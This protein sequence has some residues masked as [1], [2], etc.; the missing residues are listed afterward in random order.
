MTRDWKWVLAA[1]LLATALAI[2]TL[3]DRT[4][5]STLALR[6]AMVWDYQLQK[7]NLD[8]LQR[9]ASDLV[10]MDYSRDGTGAKALTR[11]DVERVRE[12]SDG[13]RRLVIAYLSIGE[14]EEYRYY[15]QPSWKTDPPQWLF[16]ENCRWPGN[17]LVKFW[18]SDWKRLVYDDADSYLAKI[19]AAGFDG[20]YLDR[21]DAYWDM[22]ETYPDGRARMLE[23]VAELSRKA[24]TLRKDFLVIAQNAEDLLSDTAYLTA[25]DAIAKEDLLFGVQ[26]SGQ[27]NDPKLVA[28]SISQLKRLQQAR[29]PVFVV[30]YL[31]DGPLIATARTELAALGFRPTF[32]PRAL[33][34]SDPLDQPPASPTAPSLPVGAPEYAVKHC[35]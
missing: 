25:I 35:K 11:A 6:K 13:R 33:D 2:L 14:A 28:W 16:S 32:P 21:V 31:G 15:W 3:Y 26:A 10:V 22:R 4:P 19:I 1:A 9:S 29:K 18:M 5:E 30:E 24:R 34:G 20:V 7:P 8:R 27:R 12:R 17:H 23:F